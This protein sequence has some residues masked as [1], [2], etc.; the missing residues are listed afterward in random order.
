MNIDLL[1]QDMLGIFDSFPWGGSGKIQLMMG[2]CCQLSVIGD[3]KVV[4]V[5]NTCRHKK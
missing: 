2:I 3:Y 5:V 4:S 1:K